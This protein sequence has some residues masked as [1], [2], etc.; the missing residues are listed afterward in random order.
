MLIGRRRE[1]L[2]RKAPTDLP[3][4]SGRRL[5]RLRIQSRRFGVDR[6]DIRF[7]SFRESYLRKQYRR[8]LADRIESIKR[9]GK[10]GDKMVGLGDP[11]KVG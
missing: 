5:P 8:R 6:L 11:I 4:G 2:R 7:L 10:D 3:P 9:L 1:Q